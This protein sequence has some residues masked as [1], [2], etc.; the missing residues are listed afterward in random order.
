MRAP[1][2]QP[3][4]EANAVPISSSP[5]AVLVSRFPLITE[6]FILREISEMKR[7]GQQVLLVPMLRESPPVVHLE[8]LPW[9]DSALYTPWFSRAIAAANLR[10]FLRRPVRYLGLLLRLLAGTADSLSILLRTASLFPKAVYLA[11]RLTREGVRHVHAHFATH[12]TTMA[13]IISSLS[14][15]DFS[16]TVHAH[17]IF[18]DRHLLRWK[19]RSA[20]SIRSI[21]DFNRRFLESLYPEAEGKISV[22]HVGIEPHRYRFASL[23]VVSDDSS[24]SVPTIL[25]V[26]ALKPYKGIPTLIDACSRLAGK[27]IAFRCL[28]AGEGPMR[29]RIEA[30]IERCGLRGRIEILGA[31]PQEAIA[32]LMARSTLFVL[33]SIIADDGQMEGIPVALMEAMASGLPVISSRLSGIPELI[34]NQR[35]GLLVEPGDAGALAAAIAGLLADQTMQ[36]RIGVQARRKVCEEFELASCTA[37]LLRLLNGGE[38][39]SSPGFAATC[40]VLPWRTRACEAEETSR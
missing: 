34:E 4:D 16:F 24:E 10:M 31:Q 5:V 28:I 9:M 38:H 3:L 39:S 21:S 20:R 18:V 13:L 30:M 26:A 7:Q 12:P 19:I 17:D 2:D 14:A 1:D 36:R 33:P 40:K 25:C 11:E 29:N 27:G 8:A 15:I 37:R 32:A 22:V 35:S 23:R 6:T